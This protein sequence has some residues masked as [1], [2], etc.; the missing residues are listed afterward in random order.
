MMKRLIGGLSIAVLALVGAGCTSSPARPTAAALPAVE[1]GSAQA[2]AN[3]HWILDSTSCN[4]AGDPITCSFKIAG[5]GKNQGITVTLSVHAT[6]TF[7]CRN[8]GGQNPP[9][10]QNLN[11][12]ISDSAYLV[13]EKNGQVTS[14]LS[15]T[16]FDAAPPSASDVC[17]NGN[18]TVV[19]WHVSEGSNVSLSATGLSTL[20]F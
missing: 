5:L 12:V 20:N 18:W 9:P 2:L 6:V 3:S 11:A 17:P 16:G 10:F 13:S 8:P 15:V 1:A 19:N 4:T 14:Q 7:S